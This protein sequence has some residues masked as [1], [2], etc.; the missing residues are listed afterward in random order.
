[1][2]K[3]FGDKD[4]NFKCG[5]MQL[6]TEFPFYEPGNTVT[7]TIYLRVKKEIK[8]AKGIDLEVKGGHKNGF[9]RYWN[10]IDRE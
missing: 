4:C 1:M 3:L 8:G 10:E 5:S 2:V 9:T 7:G 6:V